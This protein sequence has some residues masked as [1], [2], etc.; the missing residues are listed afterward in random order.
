M[1]KKQLTYF[2]A[3]L[4]LSTLSVA[5]VQAAPSAKFA[6]TWTSEPALASVAVIEN[7]TEDDTFV[8]EKMGYTLATIKVP[9]DKE[10]LVGVSAEIGLVTYGS[11]K[12]KNGGSGK[13]IADAEAY[14]TVMAVAK[15]GGG[16][17]TAAPGTIILSKRI[18]QLSATLGGVIQSC[19]DGDTDFDGVA[20]VDP[21]GTINFADECIVTDEEIGLLL[22]TTAAHHFNLVLPNMDQGEYDI[23]AV[24]STGAR[25]E[26]DICDSS[27]DY[28]G[29]LYDADGTV[30]V[31][32][33]AKAVIN[34]TMVTVQ[35]VR[36]A[37]GGVIDTVITEP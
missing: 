5:T 13:A 20:E 37:K 8:D 36:A 21:D 6:A 35:Q 4:A 2:T 7:A 26:V 19:T 22:N 18:Q 12:G 33:E 24:F 1:D 23:K 29:D 25:A 32:A 14:V 17:S 11:V 31:S 3:S 34:K 27:E 28:C 30:S 16:V 10:L 15:N 9:Q